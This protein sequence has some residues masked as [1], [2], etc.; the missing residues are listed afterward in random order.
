[1]KSL[2]LT[3]LLLGLVAILKAQEA[4]PDDQEDFSGI[5]YTQAMVCDRNHTDGKRP[6][7]VFPMTI[8]ALEGG[9]LEAQLTFWDNGHCH[10]KKFLMHKTDEPRKYTAFKGKKTIYIQE[11]SV[12]GYYI[13][14][15]EGQRHGK[16][17]RKGKLIGTNSEKNQEAL[18]EFKKFAMSKG[19]REENIIVPEQLDQ[20]VSAS[21]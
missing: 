17:H 16:S 8:V 6:M 9:N 10:M 15:C 19:F 18:E 4:P 14:Y 20:C 5:W 3:I 1:M 21:N 12:K 2:L 11:T 13:L 7:K